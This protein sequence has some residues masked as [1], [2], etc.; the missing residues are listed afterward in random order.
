MAANHL[1]MGM[2]VLVAI[3]GSASAWI[4][5]PEAEVLERSQPTGPS[6][7][8]QDMATERRR[9]IKNVGNEI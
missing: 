8:W 3:G 7:P 9:E 5:E 2:V 6:P 4:P 1:A